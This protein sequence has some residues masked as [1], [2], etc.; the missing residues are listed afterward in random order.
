MPPPP[1]PSVATALP[2]RT[3]KE[4]STNQTIAAAPMPPPLK[5]TNDGGS[6]LKVV[7]M[8]LAAS[9]TTA[10]PL[11]AG[12][13][14]GPIQPIKTEVSAVPEIFHTNLPPTFP[15]ENLKKWPV[16]RTTTVAKLQERRRKQQQHFVTN[17]NNNTTISN[18][19]NAAPFN[20]PFGSSNNVPFSNCN[21]SNNVVVTTPPAVAVERRCCPENLPAQLTQNGETVFTV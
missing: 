4:S 1:P 16:V 8:E 14:P 12:I 20:T 18:C 11:P 3:L 15:K 9:A 5:L 2:G 21:S 10:K 19:S 17:N 7:P 13:V 6:D